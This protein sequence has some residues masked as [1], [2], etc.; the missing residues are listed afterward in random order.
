MVSITD[1]ISDKGRRHIPAP[2]V[3]AKRFDPLIAKHMT[4][5]SGSPKLTAVQFVP[6]SVERKT[7]PPIIPSP[8]PF[9]LTKRVVSMTRKHWTRKYSVGDIGRPVLT[10][11]QRAPLLVERKTPPPRHCEPSHADAVP[12]KRFVPLTAKDSTI[13]SVRPELTG[14]QFV[15]LLLER[16]TPPPVPA[17]RLVPLTTRHDT[18]VFVRPESTAVQ[19]VPLFVD[20]KTPL[21]VPANRFDPLIARKRTVQ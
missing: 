21:P 16:K 8:L 11:V 18:L 20:L 4:F 13:V 2:E 3:P 12:A 5:V 14:V 17:K 15:P 9:M 1:V 7:P 10:V 19:L 6:L